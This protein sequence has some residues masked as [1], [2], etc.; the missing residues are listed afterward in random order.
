MASL[1]DLFTSEG[2]NIDE[3]LS[4]LKK[5]KTHNAS[6]QTDIVDDFPPL[7]TIIRNNSST[8]MAS[9]SNITE[10]V[11]PLV[12]RNF[13][14]MQETMR[15]PIVGIRGVPWRIMVMPRQ[16]V[17]QK[18]GTQKCLGFFLQCCPTAYSE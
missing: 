16:H 5:L 6:C 17:V 18:K 13:S 4:R 11:L 8:D 1:K 15:G 10:G 14:Q 12:I 2:G 9:T 3:A 7:S